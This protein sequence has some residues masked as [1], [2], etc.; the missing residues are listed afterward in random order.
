MLIDMTLVL[1]GLVCEDLIIIGDERYSK[2]GGAS[3]FQSFVYEKFFKDY[4]A[5]VNASNPDLIKEFPDESK[6]I[7]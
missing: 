1:I 3:Y 7:V 6:V 4:L 5:I 2:V